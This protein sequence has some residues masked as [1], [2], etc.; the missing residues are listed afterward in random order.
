MPCGHFF[1]FAAT[2]GGGGC[3]DLVFQIGVEPFVWIEFWTIAGKIE[4]FDF[5]LVLT[6]PRFHGLAVVNAKVVE[7]KKYFVLCVF[8]QQLHERDQSRCVE[9]ALYHHPSAL[10]PVG[11]AG[12][13]G[14]LFAFAPNGAGF[15]RFA[16]GGIAAPADAGVHDGG[17][18]SPVN[19]RPFLLRPLFDGWI[20]FI[21]PLLNGFGLLF[22]R[23][24]DGFLGREFPPSQVFAH[25]ADR[26]I[27]AELMAL[28]E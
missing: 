4:H 18:V 15:W 6:Q 21:Q 25:R 20:F 19:L 7:C 28:D 27:N 24:L 1:Q 9:G 16:A 22:V 8:H 12:N 14:K 17:F 13:Q 3:R 2:T 26:Q 11:D 5:F 10:A 23:A